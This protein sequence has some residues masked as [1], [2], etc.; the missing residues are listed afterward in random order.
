MRVMAIRRGKEWII[1]L[2]GDEVLAPRRRPVPPRLARPASPSCASSRARPSGVRPSADDDPAITDL[3][4]AVD[5]LVEMKNISEVAVGLAYSALLFNDQGLAAE[6]S[7]LEDRLDE[8]HERLEVWVLRSAADAGRPVA[9][10][11]PA[12]PRR[13]GRGDRRRRAAD[14]VARRGGRGDAPDPRASRSA[15]PTR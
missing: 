6:V 13:G 3:D 15:T 2:D 4:R 12:A 7:H 5:V 8:M 11:R 9:A 14:G 10:A 1:D